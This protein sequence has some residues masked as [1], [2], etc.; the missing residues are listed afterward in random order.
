MG[1]EKGSLTLT[2]ERKIFV[3]LTVFVFELILGDRQ[4]KNAPTLSPSLP[5][6]AEMEMEGKAQSLSLY[7]ISLA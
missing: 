3:L 6:S 1:E 5:Q 4:R 2:D 7:P